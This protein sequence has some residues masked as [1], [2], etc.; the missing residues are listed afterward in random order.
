MN[1]QDFCNHTFVRWVEKV[2]TCAVCEKQFPDI[3]YDSGFM[4]IVPRDIIEKAQKP[5][6]TNM[7][8]TFIPPLYYNL[9]DK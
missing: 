7:T 3:R 9:E 5:T 2:A 4:G 8:M 6:A 1:V